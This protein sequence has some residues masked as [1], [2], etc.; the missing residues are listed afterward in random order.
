MKRFMTMI[1]FMG[2][3]WLTGLANADIYYPTQD[4]TIV[5]SGY[6][7]TAQMVWSY[8]DDNFEGW[9]DLLAVYPG[10]I[11]NKGLIQF[12]LSSLSGPVSKAELNFSHTSNPAAGATFGLYRINGAWDAGIVTWDTAPSVEAAP[13]STMQ[14]TD[15][16][17]GVWRSFDVT[18]MVNTWLSGTPNYGMM[19][20]RVDQEIPGTYFLASES[21][22]GGPYLSVIS[23]QV[24]IPGSVFLLLPGLIGLAAVKRRE[25]R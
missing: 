12:D 5:E 21:G 17:Y 18:D 8:S 1:V 4:V 16:N 2:V 20:S 22:A 19:I 23:S 11:T 14:I 24:P 13:F 3:L 7:W 15:G 25:K 6:I 10:D 9:N